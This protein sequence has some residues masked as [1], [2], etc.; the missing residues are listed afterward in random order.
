M[1]KW[2]I[3]L[4]LSLLLTSPA[5]TQQPSLQDLAF[6]TGYWKG[7][8]F[9]G[10]S[11]EV[12]MPPS[13]GRMFGIF[14]QS[15]DNKLEFTEMI[16]IISEPD[17]IVLRLKHF[18]PDFSGWEEKDDYISFPLLHTEPNK[19]EF[20]GLVYELVS[21]DQLKITLQ[22]QESDGTRSEA[23]FELSRQP[24]EMKP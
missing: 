9:G 1:P 24:L 5:Y 21:P 11:E 17:G 20:R 15:T 22:L 7:S 2:I 19:A 4:C 6:L 18:H 3:T 8:G 13:G 10:I 23:L 16:E 12:W 14:K